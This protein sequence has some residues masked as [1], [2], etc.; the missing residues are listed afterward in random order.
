MDILDR[1]V[2]TKDSIGA[3][4]SKCFSVYPMEIES[5]L[6]HYIGGTSIICIIS[7]ELQLCQRP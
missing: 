6:M 7:S 2:H 5:L 3:S 4:V 1:K